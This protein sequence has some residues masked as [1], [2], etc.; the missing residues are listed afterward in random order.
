MK[1]FQIVDKMY[2]NRILKST[3][4]VMIVKKI[5]VKIIFR[6]PTSWDFQIK[7]LHPTRVL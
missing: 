7:N 3:D 4:D 2:L 6:F 1:F 5:I